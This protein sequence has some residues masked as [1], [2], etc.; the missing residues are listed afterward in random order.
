MEEKLNGDSILVKGAKLIYS[1]DDNNDNDNNCTNGNV[2]SEDTYV[3]LGE[4]V[5]VKDANIIW[6]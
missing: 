5:Y 6:N 3:V 2:F 1:K 4:D